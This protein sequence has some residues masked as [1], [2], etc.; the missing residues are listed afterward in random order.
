[1]KYEFGSYERTWENLMRQPYHQKPRR[2]LLSRLWRAVV[3]AFTPDIE[4]RG[5]TYDE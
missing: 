3:D 2:S 5:S 4:S 1:V